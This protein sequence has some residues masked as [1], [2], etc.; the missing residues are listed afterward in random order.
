MQRRA[1]CPGAPREGLWLGCYSTRMFGASRL[2]WQRLG[3]LCTA[4]PRVA[5]ATQLFHAALPYR[6]AERPGRAGRVTAMTLAHFLK[7]QT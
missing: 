2:H 1:C 7:T 3:S 5:Q 4:R 6:R